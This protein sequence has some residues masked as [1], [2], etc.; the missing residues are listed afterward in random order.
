MDG[1]ENCV[2]FCSSF[3]KFRNLGLILRGNRKRRRELCFI[4][5]YNSLLLSLMSY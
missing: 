2:K 5:F 4:Q 3:F 1:V